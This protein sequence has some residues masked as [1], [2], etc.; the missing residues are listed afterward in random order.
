[1]RLVRRVFVGA[2]ASL[3]LGALFT[4]VALGAEPN[5]DADAS[6]T[7]D[8]G[9]GTD[10]DLGVDTALHA[11]LGGGIDD[12]ATTDGVVSVDSATDPDGA[13][14]ADV[15][16]GPLTSPD[17][18]GEAG[19]DAD[20]DA[21]LVLDAD[22]TTFAVAGRRGGSVFNVDLGASPD[23]TAGSPDAELMLGAGTN[24]SAA[25]ADGFAAMALGTGSGANDASAILALGAGSDANDASGSAAADLAL[26][27][28]TVASDTVASDAVGGVGSETVT[29]VAATGL[30]GARG[31][32]LGI[33]ERLSLLTAVAAA[34][35]GDA[36]AGGTAWPAPYG[37][38]WGRFPTPRSASPTTLR[39]LAC[40]WPSWP[41]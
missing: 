41:G 4:G 18:A 22:E 11:I 23:G 26:G 38:S 36:P 32:V 2:A 35:G 10:G 25:D 16:V 27:A 14:T 30:G 29:D 5:A 3:A 7:L 9:V 28:G 34:G 19:T 1:M 17:V 8:P 40:S 20:A 37:R 12:A 24:D 31:A 39:C 13:S 15:T 6:I 21:Q 33:Q